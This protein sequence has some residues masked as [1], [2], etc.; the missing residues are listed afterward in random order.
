MLVFLGMF[1]ILCGI[2]LA[3]LHAACLVVLVL[4]VIGSGM[5]GGSG[6]VMA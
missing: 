4:I 1:R 3:V 2:Y 5:L 6:V